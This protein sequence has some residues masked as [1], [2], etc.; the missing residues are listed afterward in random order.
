MTGIEVC[1]CSIDPAN[2]EDA[3]ASA[4]LSASDEVEAPTSSRTAASSRSASVK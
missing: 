4:T 3:S 2:P 1:S